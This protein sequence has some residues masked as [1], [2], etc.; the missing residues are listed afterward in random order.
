MDVV[1]EVSLMILPVITSVMVMR[2]SVT[3]PLMSSEGGGSHDREME[4][5]LAGE[6]TTFWGGLD[7]AEVDT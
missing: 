7:G 1:V 5:E 3:I 4:V 2:Y 6:S